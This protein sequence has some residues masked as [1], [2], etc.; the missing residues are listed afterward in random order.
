MNLKYKLS[1]APNKKKEEQYMMSLLH[2][3]LVV[4]ASLSLLEKNPQNTCFFIKQNDT[5]SSLSSYFC[6]EDNALTLCILGT[7]NLPRQ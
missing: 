2:Y 6:L 4:Y 1:V 7:L 5:N 3:F